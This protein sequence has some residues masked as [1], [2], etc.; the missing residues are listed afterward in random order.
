MSVLLVGRFLED[1]STT[2]ITYKHYGI[3]PEDKYPTYSICFRGTNFYWRNEMAIFEENELYSHQWEKLLK[4]EPTHTYDYDLT[5][6]LYKKKPAVIRQT[7]K[8]NTFHVQI[9]DIL[10]ETNFTSSGNKLHFSNEFYQMLYTLFAIKSFLENQPFYIEFQT[11]DMICFTRESKSKTVRTE[12]VL[13]LNETMRYDARLF[14]D[15]NVTYD[16][17]FIEAVSCQIPFHE[18][19]D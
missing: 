13:V 4:G 2:T 1:R 8:F 6:K 12:D 14:P 19:A 7:S 5:S 17:T 18:K 9:M 3:N 16:N 10:I 15:K 11:P